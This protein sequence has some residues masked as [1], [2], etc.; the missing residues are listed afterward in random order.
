MS[1]EEFQSFASRAIALDV[2]ERIELITVLVKSLPQQE[3]KEDRA[4]E[5]SKINAVL[6]KIPESEQ[7]QY[8]DAGLECVRET[9]KNDT[10]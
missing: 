10:W 6:A 9:L 3:A 7:L 5:V 1:Y 4:Q 2:Q 8:C